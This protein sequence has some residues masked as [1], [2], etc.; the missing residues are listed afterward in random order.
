MRDHAVKRSAPTVTP[1]DGA[2]ETTVP[3][4]PPQREELAFSYIL[5]VLTQGLYPNVFDVLREYVQ[6]AYDAVDK[7]RK[8]YRK[9]NYKIKIDI[10]DNSVFVFDN[11]IGMDGAKI[12]KY[13]YVGYSE[14][15]ANENAGFRGIGKLSGISVA[16]HLIVTYDTRVRNRSHDQIQREEDA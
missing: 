4:I 13:R 8:A 12:K 6:N 9:R 15:K 1:T 14:K 7:H 16:E 10:T 5:E 3:A 2:V 11:G